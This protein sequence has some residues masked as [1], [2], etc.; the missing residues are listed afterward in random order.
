MAGNY[1]K[2]VTLH[3]ERKKQKRQ[4]YDADSENTWEYTRL[5]YD[6]DRACALLIR[7]HGI[8]S[9]RESSHRG[10]DRIGF[11]DIFPV[12]DT[13][14]YLQLCNQHHLAR[15]GIQG[16]GQD[17]RDTVY[18]RLYDIKR[19][20]RVYATVVS[21]A[22]GSAA[23]FYERD[24]RCPDVRIRNRSHVCAQRK[25]GRHRHRGSHRVEEEQRDC[26]QNDNVHR[27]HHHLLIVPAIPQ[28][29]QDC[30]RFRILVRAI[31]YYRRG[32]KFQ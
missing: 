31:I 18:L 29:R 2:L 32:D 8:H 6:C 13:G 28:P 5:Y 11:T 10:S 23:T 20:H 22:P 15:D 26:G 21:R 14:S 1:L 19:A 4:G 25:F 30:I 9:P 16:G 7:L 17:F 27:F 24:N 3:P 12:F